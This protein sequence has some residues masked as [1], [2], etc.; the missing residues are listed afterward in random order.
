MSSV[1]MQK[2]KYVSESKYYVK[3]SSGNGSRDV[4]VPSK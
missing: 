1:S 4:S 2:A 3:S